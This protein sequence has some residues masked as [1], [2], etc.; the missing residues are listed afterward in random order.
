MVLAVQGCKGSKSTH[1]LL[2][3]RAMG[4]DASGHFFGLRLEVSGY[5]GANR[6]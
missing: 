5:K 6:G 1:T 3:A 4:N 2:D